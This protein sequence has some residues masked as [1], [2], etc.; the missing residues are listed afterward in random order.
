M[1]RRQMTATAADAAASAAHSW[2]VIASKAA[3][4]HLRRAAAT[5]QRYRRTAAVYAH[6]AAQTSPK[7]HC[8]TRGTKPRRRAARP[9]RA[10]QRRRA[11]SWPNGPP[12]SSTA[13]GSDATRSRPNIGGAR[14]QTRR[15]P[16]PPEARLQT[17]VRSLSGAAL[18]RARNPP[19]RRTRPTRPPR[20]ARTAWS[21]SVP[22]RR[23]SPGRR[24][25]PPPPQ[26]PAARPSHRIEAPNLRASTHAASPPASASTPSTSD[27]TA[28]A[29]EARI[30]TSRASNSF[31][32]MCSGTAS[33][34]GSTSSAWCGGVA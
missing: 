12:T 9:P 3:R 28:E 32:N 19:T 18:P 1:L 26:L 16:Q 6:V 11:D 29:L 8:H 31:Q 25:P 24:R 22:K 20:S 21:G 2:V 17:R 33:A 30:A 27:G 10:A 13:Q 23:A 15:R 7:S 34:R 4:R 5:G 14:R